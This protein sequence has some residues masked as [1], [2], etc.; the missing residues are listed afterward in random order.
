MKL[1]FKCVY[2]S[3]VVHKWARMRASDELGNTHVKIDLAG[4]VRRKGKD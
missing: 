3:V 1:A 4:K 2:S